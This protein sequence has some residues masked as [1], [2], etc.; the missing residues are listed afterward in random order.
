M[1]QVPTYVKGINWEIA[2]AP[3]T[4]DTVGNLTPQTTLFFTGQWT[5]FSI[6]DDVSLEDQTS[7]DQF[8]MNEVPIGEK[9]TFEIEEMLSV[10]G[11]SI[12]LYL[13]SNNFYYV[14]VQCTSL[15][16][17]STYSFYAVRNSIK[18]TVERGVTKVSGTFTS[19]GIEPT[20]GF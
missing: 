15:V 13:Q 20:V 19:V 14:F 7:S 16:T 9:F 4:I 2:L 5:R 11:G 17:S 8:V 10:G 6:S 3:C 1:P 12:L 18:P